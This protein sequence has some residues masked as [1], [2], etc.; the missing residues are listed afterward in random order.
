MHRPIQF[1]LTSRLPQKYLV[2]YKA[3]T[4]IWAI[5][6]REPKENDVGSAYFI[7]ILANISVNV[8]IQMNSTGY[9]GTLKFYIQL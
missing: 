5:P 4:M 6:M 2:K 9:R 3:I 7:L 8:S 1:V